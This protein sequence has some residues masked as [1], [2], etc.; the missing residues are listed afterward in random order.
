MI[1]N[2]GNGFGSGNGL[3]PEQE[4]RCPREEVTTGSSSPRSSSALEALHEQGLKASVEG[5]DRG[6]DGGVGCDS[7]PRCPPRRPT[8]YCKFHRWP[9]GSLPA[10]LEGRQR[11]SAIGFS[12]YGFASHPKVLNTIE[13]AGKSSSEPIGGQLR[14]W[15]VDIW[16]EIVERS[17]AWKEFWRSIPHC[18]LID[19]KVLQ[20]VHRKIN[21]VASHI[22]QVAFHVRMHLSQSWQAP[23]IT[24]L[25][26]ADF[27]QGTLS[28]PPC[29]P[30]VDSHTQVLTR[31]GRGQ[32]K[33]LNEVYGV[34]GDKKV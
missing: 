7:P 19:M 15:K 3:I 22:Y 11:E 10:P 18:F 21:V 17:V 33:N 13:V 23:A 31:C 32:F 16:M 1:N 8:C 30:W 27:E 20:K 9:E 25:R 26:N 28:P 14:I 4:A 5:G 34:R 12:E 6:A 2:M 29:L 24:G